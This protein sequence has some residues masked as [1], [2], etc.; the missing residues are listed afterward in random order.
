MVFLNA[1]ILLVHLMDG[2]SYLEKN[3]SV[4]NGLSI[5]A[6]GFLDMEVVRLI[7]CAT[8]LLRVHISMPMPA[9]ID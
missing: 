1:V 5:T 3:S 8:S 6:P 2:Q 4:A 9:L 7:F